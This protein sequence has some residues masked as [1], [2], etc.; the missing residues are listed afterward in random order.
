[1]RVF[2]LESPKYIDICIPRCSTVEEVIRHLLS[3]I[4]NSDMF[5][6]EFLAGTS[7]VRDPKILC[8]PDIYELRLLDDEEDYLAPSLDMPPLGR[9]KPIGD[10]GLEAVALCRI[11]MARSTPCSGNSRRHADSMLPSKG[12]VCT[13]S[14]L[15]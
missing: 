15:G 4:K 8:S 3:T 14:R 13:L 11:K 9:F 2:I 5:R 12:N 7:G 6:R 1:M 10:F